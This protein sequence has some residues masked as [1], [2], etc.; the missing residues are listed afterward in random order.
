MKKFLTILLAVMMVLSCACFA[1]AEEK[2]TV[3]VWTSGSQNVG[4]LYNALA[5]AY[6]AKEDAKYNVEVQFILSG[7][8][9]EGLASRLAS[10]YL[11]GQ[12]NTSFDLIDSNAADI[13][14]YMDQAGS[15]DLFL[16]LDFSKIE[17]YEN[18]QTKPAVYEN[19]LVPYRCTTVVFAYDSARVSE[20]ELPHTWDELADWIKAHPGRFAYNEP[21]T[22]VCP[23]L[24]RRLI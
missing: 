12:T 23:C 18:V 3:T 8:G 22:G 11:A 6:N 13:Q 15:E 17:G 19:K 10:A 24:F 7:T 1:S 16:D 21:D 5:A 20:E 9:D 2:Q 4:D 14:G